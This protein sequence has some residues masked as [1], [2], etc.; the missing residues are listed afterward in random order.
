MSESDSDVSPAGDVGPDGPEFAIDNKFYSEKDKKEIMSLTEVQREEILAERAVR[1]EK[2]LQSEQLRRMLMNRE[3]ESKASD[4]KRKA[5]DLDESP[6]KSSR[7]KTTL[8]GRKVG[9]ASGAIEAYKR[10]REEKNLR[11]QQRK[12]EGASRRDRKARSSSPNRGSSADAEGES[13]VEWDEGKHKVDDERSRHAEHADYHDFRRATLPRF[14]FADYC[15]YPGFPNAVRDCYV[16][17]AAKPKSNG[18]V[19]YELALIKG[20][21]TLLRVT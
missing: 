7:Q 17:L 15:F 9:E 4:K 14:A 11:D 19:G 21:T 12:R 18:D 13:E 10:Q 5:T 1:L 6:R 20:E 16:R 8:C 2:K 3:K